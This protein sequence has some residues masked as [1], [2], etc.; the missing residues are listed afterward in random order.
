MSSVQF[1][2]EDPSSSPPMFRS[3]PPIPS[4]PPLSSTPPFPSSPS[5]FSDMNVYDV[6]GFDLLGYERRRGIVLFLFLKLKDNECTV[7]LTTC[8]VWFWCRESYGQ[9]SDLWLETP[10]CMSEQ[11]MLTVSPPLSV[12]SSSPESVITEDEE[13]DFAL[14]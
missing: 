12:Y 13:S 6:E 14:P 9:G 11:S 1:S 2:S 5:L 3:S 10:E 8:W 7:N 4:S